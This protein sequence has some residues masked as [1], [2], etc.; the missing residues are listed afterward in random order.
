MAKAT[1]RRQRQ[2]RYEISVHYHYEISGINNMKRKARP[3]GCRGRP[4]NFLTLDFPLGVRELV[5]VFLSIPLAT[6]KIA[7]S[8]SNI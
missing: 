4:K 2:C 8:I 5:F 1:P 3:P 6:Q 7:N